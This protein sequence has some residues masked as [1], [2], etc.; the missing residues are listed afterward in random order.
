MMI[1]R[2]AYTSTSDP[3]GSQP[4]VEDPNTEERRMQVRRGSLWVRLALTAGLAVTG[5][6]AQAVSLGQVDTFETGLAGWASGA[7]HPDPPRVDA[8][9]GPQGAGDAWLRLSAL[10]G[11]GAG[12]RLVAFSGP[13][14]GGD[15]GAAGI[16]GITMDANNYGDLDVDLRLQFDSITGTVISSAAR[17]PARS[18][19]TPI[20]FSL[21]PAD[22][23]GTAGLSGVTLMRLVNHPGTTGLPP[24]QLALVG[25][26]NVL[27]SAVPEP[28]STGLLALGL[29]A[30]ASRRQIR[31]TIAA[32]PSH[33]EI[34]K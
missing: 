6:T 33:K 24:Q 25:I 21:S 11:T 16:A 31:Q 20:F 10:G 19:W 13:Q 29:L 27:A 18:G 30:L 9:G 3:A 23:T 26:D 34:A 8:E 5:A 4:S 28:A 17:L 2:L 32:T 7:N 14:W 22:L 12:S 1:G 15:Y